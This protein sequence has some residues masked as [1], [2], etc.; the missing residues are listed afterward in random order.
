MRGIIE[1]AISR[2]SCQKFYYAKRHTY[3]NHR[4]TRRQRSRRR[5]HTIVCCDWIWCIKVRR[6]LNDVSHRSHRKH[7]CRRCWRHLMHLLAHVTFETM[8][9]CKRRLFFFNVLVQSSYRLSMRVRV[10][11]DSNSFSNRIL[12]QLS[13]TAFRIRGRL[14]E[15]IW[16]SNCTRSHRWLS[17]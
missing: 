1:K 14:S 10:R 7:F 11:V 3:T 2:F 16:T 9:D 12:S 6:S 4:M 15:S 13:R 17:D 5:D 8:R